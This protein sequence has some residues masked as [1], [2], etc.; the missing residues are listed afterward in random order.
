MY[1]TL[2]LNIGCKPFDITLLNF[3]FKYWVG[4]SKHRNMSKHTPDGKP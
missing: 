1:E 4:I 3:L 2:K